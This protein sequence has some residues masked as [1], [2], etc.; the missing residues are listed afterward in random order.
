VGIVRGAYGL[1]ITGLG[2][3]DRHLPEV[4][5]SW[6]ELHLDQT[7]LVGDREPEPPGTIRIEPDRAELWLAEAG[8]ILVQREPLTVSFATVTPLSADAVLHPFLG[9]PAAIANRWL[10][11][12]SLHGGAFAYRDRAWA[13]LGNREA[14]KSATLG[15]LLKAGHHILSDD[16]L[17]LAGTQLF[18][19]PRSIDLRADAGASVGGEALGVVGNRARWRLR[20]AAGPPAMPLGGL[21]SLEWAQDQMIEPMDTEA[22][23]RQLIGSS[24]LRPEASSA[25]RLLELA[26]LPAWRFAR[27]HSLAD[28]GRS[29]ELLLATLDTA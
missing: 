8:R 23:L 9:L 6:P 22:R 27:R 17:V 7:S 14:G 19:G 18:A 2:S 10:G 13:L 15:T 11:R 20:P 12:I 29:I 21:I 1:R 28:I 4:P 5:A 3:A 26:A 16:I 25:A 24:A